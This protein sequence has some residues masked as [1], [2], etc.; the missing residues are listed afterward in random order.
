MH[1]DPILE[2]AWRIKDDHAAR[3]GCDIR[4]MARELKEEEE[5]GHRKVVSFQP[6]RAPVKPSRPI[7]G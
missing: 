2:E 4:E 1:K 3:H 7:E 6:R 5:K